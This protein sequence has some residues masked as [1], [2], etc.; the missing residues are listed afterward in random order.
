MDG[1][2][3]GGGG[4][5]EKK[6]GKTNVLRKEFIVMAGFKLLEEGQEE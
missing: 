5:E 4:E 2:R 1:M 3:R 6:K